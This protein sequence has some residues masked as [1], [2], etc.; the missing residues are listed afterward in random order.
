MVS[1]AL[2]GS[3]TITGAVNIGAG[4][5]ASTSLVITSSDFANH[6]TNNGS[7]GSL[8]AANTNGYNY[9]G[10][11]NLIDPF[12]VLS[13]PNTGTATRIQNAFTAAGLDINHVYVFDATFYLENLG[14]GQ[15][16]GT[17]RKVR[18]SYYVPT[19]NLFVLAVDESNANWT[20]GPYSGTALSGQFTFPLT[21]N[22]SSGVQN[23]T[24]GNS[25][26][27]DWC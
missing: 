16:A 27:G 22:V 15:Q 11:G 1:V 6:G 25:T 21:I 7:G 4:G 26:A 3:M 12:Y 18:I 8:T 17:S 23:N 2:T 14:A 20:T 19:N 5:G 13:N 9:S 24:N 10:T